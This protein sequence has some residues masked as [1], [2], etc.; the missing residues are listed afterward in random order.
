M[1]LSFHH[2]G[3]TTHMLCELDFTKWHLAE[4]YGVRLLGLRQLAFVQ[5]LNSEV[6]SGRQAFSLIHPAKESTL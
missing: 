1:F 5:N 2:V 6:S 3:M 4:L